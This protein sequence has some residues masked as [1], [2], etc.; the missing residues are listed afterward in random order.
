[1]TDKANL[2]ASVAVR[3]LKRAKQTG[4]DYQTLLTRLFFKRCVFND[5]VAA[6]LCAPGP[7]EGASDCI[8]GLSGIGK[9]AAL[10]A[11]LG[12]APLLG[13]CRPNVIRLLR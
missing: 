13:S 2:A 6:V 4:N 12:R 11:A 10:K 1:M 5:A 8:L 7:D 3:L 9:S